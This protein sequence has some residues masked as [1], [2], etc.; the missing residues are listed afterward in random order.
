LNFVVVTLSGG[1]AL[2]FWRNVLTDL[3]YE[4]IGEPLRRNAK[5]A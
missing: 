5:R 3:R 1:Y 2:E 4:S